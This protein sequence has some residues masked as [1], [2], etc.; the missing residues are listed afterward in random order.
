MT[1]MNKTSYMSPLVNKKNCCKKYCVESMVQWNWFVEVPG[2]IIMFYLVVWENIC[3][4]TT[5]VWNNL[6]AFFCAFVLRLSALIRVYPFP[7]P[8]VTERET[9][10][11]FVVENFLQNSNKIRDVAVLF[12]GHW[13]KQ[14]EKYAAWIQYVAFETYLNCPLRN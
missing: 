9:N 5:D 6:C 10:R 8:L 12:H 14:L 11:M 4:R 3:H 2:G 1:F 13:L 7:D